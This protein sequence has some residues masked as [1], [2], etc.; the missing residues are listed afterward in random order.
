MVMAGSHLGPVL[1][2]HQD[3][4]FIGAVDVEA[5]GIDIEQATPLEMRAGSIEI[6]HVRLLHGSAPNTS[7]D[8]R[9]LLLFDIAAVD[10][11]PI[12]QPIGDLE[13]Y[14]A[15]IVR[16]TPQEPRTA[17]QPPVRMPLPRREAGTIFEVQKDLRARAF[18]AG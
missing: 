15:L 1:D 12:G 11:F 3:G 10:A 14:D 8:P 9:R 5:S 7:P 13:A 17:E 4:F 2:H 6:H 16:G 18:E